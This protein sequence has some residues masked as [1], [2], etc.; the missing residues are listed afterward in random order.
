MNVP[1]TLLRGTGPVNV[2]PHVPAPTWTSYIH[3]TINNLPLSSQQNLNSG[4]S[5]HSSECSEDVDAPNLDL[6]V[7][8]LVAT[9]LEGLK[10]DGGLE[11]GLNLLL[12]QDV[13]NPK[14]TSRLASAISLILHTHGSQAIPQS[15]LREYIRVTALLKFV[16][17]WKPVSSMSLQFLQL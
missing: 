5:D 6:K 12:N 7:H 13:S 15:R 2:I 10:S 8:D 3:P 14:A 11:M 4:L 1:S 16:E 9:F 17:H